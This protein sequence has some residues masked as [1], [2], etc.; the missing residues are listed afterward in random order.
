[1]ELCHPAQEDVSAHRAVHRGG[2]GVDS[3]G[4]DMHRSCGGSA[5]FDRS[6]DWEPVEFVSEGRYAAVVPKGGAGAGARDGKVRG[7]VLAAGAAVG[8]GFEDYV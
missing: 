4:M 6:A 7:A 2:D 1:M 5:I 3:S 8:G